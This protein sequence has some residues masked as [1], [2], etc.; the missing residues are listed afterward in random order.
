MGTDRNPFGFIF[1]FIKK[2]AESK[3]LLSFWKFPD[4]E[5]IG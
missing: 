2:H 5:P 3:I 1:N 4:T